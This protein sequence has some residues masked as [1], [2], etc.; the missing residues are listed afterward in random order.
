MP[1]PRNQYLTGK[2]K[3]YTFRPPRSNRFF[4]W[5]AKGLLPLILHRS[6]KI[7]EVEV[8]EADLRR[9]RELK[10]LRVILTPNHAQGVE[11]AI[12]FH[13][14]KLLNEEF[15]YLAAKDAFEHPSPVPWLLQRLG[16]YSVVR[17]TPDRDSFRMTRQLL[18]DGQRW[19]V[20]F[21][22]GEVC[23]QDDT[24]MPFQQGVAQLAFWA[25]DD[26][27]KQGER[28]LLY[29]VPIAI[30]YVYIRNMRLEID[31]SLQ[32]L[33]RKLFSALTLHPST[34][35]DRLRRVG[36]AVLSANEKEYNVRPREGAGL[37]E[38]VQQMK[39]L[40]TARVEAALRVSPRP[41]QP[42]LERTRNLF[43][44]LDRIVY[45]EPEA[46]EYERQLHHRRQQEIRMLY[47]DLSQVLRFVALYDGYVRETLTAE[48][49][50]D[51]LGRLELEVFGKRTI[52][53]SRKAIMKIGEP[54]NLEDYFPRYKTDKRGT[55]Q[56]IMTSLEDSVR[57]MLSEL[58]RLT[59]PIEPVE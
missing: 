31:R 44:S 11:P 59:K 17:G 58:S 42:L 34:L 53:G 26:L 56:E 45:S 33:E 9:L 55:L 49:F 32:Q 27:V 37:N 10:R 30:K 14:S 52:W 38:R 4:I 43:N 36:E 6:L 21:P 20:V 40:I 19:L 2:P 41:E 28:P 16:A 8:N 29:F 57:K 48:R 25:Y 15:N 54:L 23:W 22:E 39:E 7:V 46:P 47:D 51:V 3:P 1:A 35:Y 13:L 5:L 12:V 18:L 50:L 24:V